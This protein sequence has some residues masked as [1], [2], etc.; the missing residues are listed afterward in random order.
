MRVAGASRGGVPVT[1]FA[2]SER[3]LI[4]RALQN[5]SGN[6]VRTAEQLKISRKKLYARITKYRLSL[7]EPHSNRRVAR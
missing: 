7:A 6:K 3:E 5:N 2:E 4:V 1:T